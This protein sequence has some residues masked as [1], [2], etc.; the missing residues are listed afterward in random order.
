MNPVTLGLAQFVLLLAGV[1]AMIAVLIILL[2]AMIQAAPASNSREWMSTLGT[3][4]ASFIAY[5]RD[6]QD[7]QGLKAYYVPNVAYEYTVRGKRQSARRIHFG[8]PSRMAQK[9]AAENALAKYPVGARVDVFY[10]P[11]KPDD[12]V[13][14]RQ[15]P[16]ARRFGLVALGVLASGLVACALAFLL[17]GWVS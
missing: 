14:E 2:L 5:E 12:A 3:I 16:E 11:D 10:N 8:A 1:G 7:P 15:A 17:P 4:I 9:S 6:A 13:L